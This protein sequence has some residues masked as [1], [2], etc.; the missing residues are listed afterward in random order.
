LN[1]VIEKKN[2]GSSEKLQP[3]TPHFTEGMPELEISDDQIALADELPAE[4][5]K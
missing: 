2:Y 3:P 5:I 4:T 1:T